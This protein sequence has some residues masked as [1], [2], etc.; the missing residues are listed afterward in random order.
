MNCCTRLP[1]SYGGVQ[2]R[3][4]S[5]VTLS[6]T[7]VVHTDQTTA[8]LKLRSKSAKAKG[9]GQRAKVKPFVGK[10]RVRTC[11]HFIHQ[12][13]LTVYL[14][15][16]GLVSLRFEGRGANSI[17]EDKTFSKDSCIPSILQ[18]LV[19]DVFL[20]RTDNDPI[21]VRRDGPQTACSGNRQAAAVNSKA[22]KPGYA[23]VRR[24]ALQSSASARPAFL[25]QGA[26]RCTRLLGP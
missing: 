13:S 6:S 21:D 12:S 10:L 25:L 23:R 7:A 20:L 17:L 9:K 19:S 4:P 22:R 24:N 16:N 18:V 1:K 14:N 5:P 26:D 11:G 15:R 8:V 3:I 2:I